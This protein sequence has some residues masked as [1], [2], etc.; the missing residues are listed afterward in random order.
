MG[1]EVAKAYPIARQTFESADDILG[2][3]LSRICF[4][5][6]ED[7][8]TQTEITQ[9]ALF[10][11]SVALLRAIQNQGVEAAAAAG[12]SVGEYA[13]L[14]AAA[15]IRFEDALPIVRTRGELMAQ[16]V[17]DTPGAMAAIIGLDKETVE[18]ICHEASR[19]G[20][21]EPSNLNAPTQIVISGHEVAVEATMK[22]SVEA[23]GKAVRLN[24]SA[25]FHC[26]LMQPVSEGLGVALRALP[27]HEP[28]IP[29]IGNVTGRPLSTAHD[30]RQAL[31]DQVVSPVRWTET[32]RWALDWG[33]DSFLEIGPGRV[34]AGLLKATD[35]SA[36]IH[37]V[38]TP[39]DIEK[40]VAQ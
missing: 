9:P 25:P 30:V 11:T 19:L 35:R 6:P 4:E 3:R 5:G 20:V 32:I 33:A 36:R 10:T 1:R 7:A 22:L 26:S 17:V 14:V 38:A 23:G 28:R 21:A 34:L 39:D 15:A 31:V 8:L 29:V 40:L 13:A 18:S 12:H 16:T 2:F 37:G 24:V 27:I